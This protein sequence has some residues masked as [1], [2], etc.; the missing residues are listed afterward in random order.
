[1]KAKV[2]IILSLLCIYSCNKQED[3]IKTILPSQKWIIK[4][5]YEKDADSSRVFRNFE[6]EF[7]S[8]NNTVVAIKGNIKVYGL[9][10]VNT[11]ADNSKNIE[12][13]FDKNNNFERISS[14]WKVGSFDCSKISMSIADTSFLRSIVLESK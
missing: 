13:F 10:A 11:S 8:A 3:T 2:F 1:M 6:L 7:E 4:Q 9:W 14:Y 12:L 5:Y